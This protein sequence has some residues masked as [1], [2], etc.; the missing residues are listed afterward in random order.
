[1]SATL[2]LELGLRISEGI[3]QGMTAA[4]EDWL[5]QELGG[6]YRLIGHLGG[7]GFG[8]TY[9][10]E[11]VHLP[12]SPR[13]VVK[14]L[15]PQFSDELSAATAK[16]LFET[17]ARVLYH[18]GHC[19]RIPRLLAHFEEQD[20]FYLVQEYIDGDNLSHEV[21]LGQSLPEAEVIYL[22]RDILDVLAIIHQENVIHRDLKPSN[23]IRRRTDGRIVLID[24]GAVKQLGAKVVSIRGHTT[25]TIAIGSPG[26]MP[27]EQLAGKPR[28]CSDLYAV[29]MIG[30]QALT[31]VHPRDLPEE[32]T[33]GE[34]R[35]RDRC[36]VNPVFADVLDKLVRYD[37]RQRYQTAE[38]V[39]AELKPLL[40]LYPKPQRLL[41]FSNDDQLGFMTTASMSQV[42]L[43]SVSG[44]DY[45]SLQDL[46]SQQAWPAADAETQRILLTLC[47]RL[48]PGI[49]S[50]DCIQDIPCRDLCTIDYLWCHY[51]D[52]QFGFSIQKRIWREVGGSSETHVH[53][54]QVLTKA[55]RSGWRVNSPI[56]RFGKRVGW[57]I[58]HTWIAPNHLQFTSDAPR[59]H[60]PAWHLGSVGVEAIA[61][62]LARLNGCL[63]E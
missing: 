15:H 59:G 54:L 46:L 63:P 39:L 52:R 40:S 36:S 5:G 49:L 23:L 9:L 13:C 10:A 3:G 28:F 45:R 18:L 57:R 35:W 26:Y 44:I 32:G 14:K 58:K 42:F 47:D 22:L 12:D 8:Q 11:D 53:R 30:I 43:D 1:M 60:L 48:E 16:R 17:E 21:V 61:A 34:I 19:D 27:N 37:F 38:I 55:N 33:T 31:G 20:E 24:F 29:G 50:L 62:F 51:S 2:E 41:E 25:W 6:R 7:G 4:H 56:E